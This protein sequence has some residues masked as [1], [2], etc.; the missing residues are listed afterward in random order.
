MMFEQVLLAGGQGS[1][2]FFNFN[3]L[4]QFNLL[5]KKNRTELK[6]MKDQLASICQ[7][8]FYFILFYLIFL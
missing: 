8:I 2:A 1:V 5:E 6:E 3:F 4:Y 7:H